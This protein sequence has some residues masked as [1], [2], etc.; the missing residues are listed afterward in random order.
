MEN[1]ENDSCS[2]GCSDTHSSKNTVRK[3]K[4]KSSLVARLNRVEGQIRGIKGMIEKDV[5]CDDILNQIS[6]ASS[7]LDAISKLVLENHIRS[8]FVEKIKAGDDEIVDEL[9]VTIGKIL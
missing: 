5:Y 7:A 3:P 8:C 6:A 4:L 9:I 2:V 1:I